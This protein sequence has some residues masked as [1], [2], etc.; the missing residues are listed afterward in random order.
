MG[1]IFRHFHRGTIWLWSVFSIL[2]AKSDLCQHQGDVARLEVPESGFRAVRRAGAAAR[3][4]GSF[5]VYATMVYGRFTRYIQGFAARA[6]VVG[7][8]QRLIVFALDSEAHAQCCNH[9]DPVLCVSGSVSVLNKFF[10]PLQVLS[11]GFDVVW[12]DFDIYLFADPTPH[13][14]PWRQA[15]HAQHDILMAYAFES[16]CLCN[17]FFFMRS[18]PSVVRWLQKLLQWLYDNPFEHDQRAMAALL[19]YTERISVDVEQYLEQAVPRWHV[20]D[21]ENRF[22]HFGHWTGDADKIVL[23]H[24]MDGSA[25]DLYGRS[26]WDASVNFRRPSLMDIFYGSSTNHTEHPLLQPHLSAVMQRQWVASPPAKRQPCGILPNVAGAHE[27]L[28]WLASV[29]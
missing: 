24:F 23:F 14:V 17:G 7:I 1:S 10:L 15:G 16:D 6:A 28:G 19:N 11:L 22:L 3:Q 9:H 18:R 12:L 2:T 5:V 13:L 4:I 27:G 20:L 25:F 21:V 29:C 26:D 8:A